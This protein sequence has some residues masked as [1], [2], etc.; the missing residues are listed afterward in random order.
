MKFTSL[1][2]VLKN[3]ELY[4]EAE[5]NIVVMNKGIYAIIRLQSDIIDFLL[6]QGVLKNTNN[7]I[8]VF[9]E[10]KTYLDP[11]ITFFDN[12]DEET[13]L[14]L[15]KA[16]GGNGDI[17]YW[18]TLQQQV[19]DVHTDFV[20]N[21]LEEYNKKEAK[22]FNT[23]AFEIIRDL[24]TFFKKDF[25]ERLED[26]FGKSW[27]KKGVPPQVAKKAN[28]IAFDKNLKIE[29]EEDEVE[30]WDCLTIIAYRA[31][32]LK[33]WR[34][35]FEKHYTKPTEQKISGGKEAKTQWM[36]KLEKLRNENFHQYSVTEDEFSFLSELHDWL[37]KK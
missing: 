6:E 24:E 11:I 9:E 31:I 29:N 15:R 26:K 7:P 21:G 23:K 12:I 32:A 27:F 17:K 37:I 30:V 18:R 13:E 16:Y 3:E 8:K 14:A 20:P 2:V 22:E 34:D 36:V 1:R 28:D 5:N 10:S 4:R 35:V 33:N 19:S 25:Q